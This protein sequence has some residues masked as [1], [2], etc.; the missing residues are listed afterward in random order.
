MGRFSLLLGR[1]LKV[2]GLLLV[3][4]FA[5]LFFFIVPL[6]IGPL[7]LALGI[8]IPVGLAAIGGALCVVGKIIASNDPWLDSRLSSRGDDE[9]FK[10]DEEA[11]G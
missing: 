4:P 11:E 6:G 8:L 1:G 10:P 9:S 3:A 7:D 5:F 2:V